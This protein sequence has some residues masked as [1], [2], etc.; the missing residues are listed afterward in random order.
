MIIPVYFCI[1]E[2]ACLVFFFFEGFIFILVTRGGICMRSE[3]RK[4]KGEQG[5]YMYD[6]LDVDPVIIVAS[7]KESTP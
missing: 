2:A 1:C 7:F 5:V 3:R 6:Y 4:E